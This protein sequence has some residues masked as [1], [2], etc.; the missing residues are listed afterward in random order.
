[1][2]PEQFQELVERYIS[3]QSAPEEIKKLCLLLEEPGYA[4]QLQGLMDKQ[5]ADSTVTGNDYPKVVDRLKNMI[6]KEIV[7]EKK[8]ARIF[9][10][11]RGWRWIG[12]AAVVI[13]MAGIGL[14]LYN[15]R[16][17]DL[18]TGVVP[19]SSTSEIK[20]GKDGAILTLSDGRTIILDSAANGLIAMQNGAEVVLQDGQLVYKAGTAADVVYNTMSTPKGRQ[21]R[22][23]LPDG[24]TAWLNAA[25]SLH[26]PIAFT[27]RE[28]NVEVTGEVYFEVAK[29][30]KPFRVKA[31]E[32]MEVAVLG[33][34]FNINSYSN[35]TS[36]NTTLLE[37]SVQIINGSHKAMLIPGQQ[38]QVNGNQKIKVVNGVNLKKVMAWKNGVFDFNDA[39][40]QEVMHQLERWYDIEVVYERGVPDIEFFGTMERNLSLDDVLK[41]L[42]LSEVNLRMEGRKLIVVR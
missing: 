42:K 32:D 20:P 15:T 38:A 5:L 37:G 28:R 6:E 25:S 10:L 41:G 16:N 31:N 18:V 13:V 34:H 2:E 36:I 39:S 40:L 30:S 3:E 21:F 35:E 12:A 29:S 7:Q 26:Y 8:S 33:T 24:T 11:R 17:T 22:I 14:I 27:G 1:M 9:P 4:A 19:V 23:V